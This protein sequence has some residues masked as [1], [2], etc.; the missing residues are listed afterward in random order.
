LK[1]DKNIYHEIYIF[2]IFFS[3][4]YPTLLFAVYRWSM[5]GLMNR[6]FENFRTV[7]YNFDF[8]VYF[9]F[10]NGKSK[11][12]LFVI[13]KRLLI[14]FFGTKS[15]IR[16][17]NNKIC[18]KKIKFWDTQFVGYINIQRRVRFL[19]LQAKNRVNRVDIEN[20]PKF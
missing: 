19:H 15:I 2:K 5:W 13:I 18:K 3:S 20:L 1:W 7:I 11:I 10:K 4:L 16:K 8:H 9:V 14:F 12:C 17:N 6:V